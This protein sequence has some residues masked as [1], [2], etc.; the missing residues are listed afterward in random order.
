MRLV[1]AV[2]PLL[3]LAGC[4]KKERHLLC[5][6][7]IEK[8]GQMF[9]GRSDIDVDK[10]K[11]ATEADAKLAAGKAACVEFAAR[12]GGGYAGPL[13]QEALRTCTAA[14]RPKDLLRA[15]CEDRVTAKPWNPRDGL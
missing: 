1:A 13:Y 3:L 8:D 6:A 14:V 15:R 10:E 9:C 11:E 5:D 2:L 12:K 4:T 7:C